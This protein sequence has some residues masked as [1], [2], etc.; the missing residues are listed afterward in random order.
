VLRPQAGTGFAQM[1]VPEGLHRVA[2]AY[3]TSVAEVG[4]LVLSGLTLIGLIALAV[5]P[6]GRGAKRSP[7]ALVPEARVFAVRNRQAPA[8]WLLLVLTG[9]LVAK[10]LYVDDFTTWLRC[11]STAARVCG[12]DQA[13]SVAFEG[14][15]R[16]RGYS[17]PATRV[18]PGGELRLDLF[19]QAD[20]QIKSGQYSFLRLRSAAGE[21]ATNPKT[22]DDIWVEERHEGPG[23][24][25]TTGYLPERLYA[26]TYRITVPPDLPS[27]EYALEIGWYDVATGDQLTL[28]TTELPQELRAEKDAILLSG[29][30]VP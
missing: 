17:L 25:F 6:R 5:W 26:D 11:V 14:D 22:G 1:D 13:V 7:A 23:G 4:G 27:G 18:K 20:R 24:F 8:L 12:A 29:I 10:V 15:I 28:Q 3:G 9:L 16:L 19:W 2:L 30:T 21:G